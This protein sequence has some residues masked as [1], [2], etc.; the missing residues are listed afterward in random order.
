MSESWAT[1][2]PHSQNS[3]SLFPASLGPSAS[4]FSKSLPFK[5][6]G[7]G[8]KNATDCIFVCLRC[9][10]VLWEAHRLCWALECMCFSSQI[11]PSETSRIQT[12]PK[13]SL[14]LSAVSPNLLLHT[15]PVCFFFSE[16]WTVLCGFFFFLLS[17]QFCQAERSR[18]SQ[19]VGFLVWFQSGLKGSS[20]SPTFGQDEEPWW[21]WWHLSFL[22]KPPT[23]SLQTPPPPMYLFPLAKYQQSLPTF[24][25]KMLLG[26]G[27]V[28]FK[29]RS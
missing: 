1:I 25:N 21:A 3:S 12:Y 18:S 24:Q 20:F 11:R 7:V 27:G 19:F 2:I 16:L 22:L 28:I 8:C 23:L 10:Q 15:F 26:C 29:K 13:L 14:H 5:S 6:L 4:I 17:F 9:L